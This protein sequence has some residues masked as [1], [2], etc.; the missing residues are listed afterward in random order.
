M[1]RLQRLKGSATLRDMTA[2]VGFGRSQLIQPLFIAQGASRSEPIPGLRDNLTLTANDA[3]SQID[4]DLI[5]GVRQFILFPVPAQKR[6]RGFDTDFIAQ[7]IRGAKLRFGGDATLWVDTCLC[8]FTHS[9]HCCIVDERQRQNLSVSLQ[10]LAALALA[11]AAA[12]A[13]GISPSDMNDCRVAHLRASLDAAG[14]EMTPIMSY[15]AKFASQFYGPFRAA[16]QSAPQFGDRRGY[17]LDVRSA[18]DA[19]AASVRC[20]EEGAD[21][22]MV[23]PGMSSLDLIGPIAQLTRKP[24]GAFQVSGEFASLA[25]LAREGLTDFDA[26]LLETWLVLRRAGA[27]FIISY[28]ARQAQSLGLGSI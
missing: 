20:A 19:I 16:A 13:D 21:L 27:S 5:A 4:R 11:Y 26:A 7:F 3:L 22:L 12:G 28:G 25:L 14:F 15:S 8:S 6:E 9:G 18:R 10:E 24:V 17:Q 1:K 2:E 23:K